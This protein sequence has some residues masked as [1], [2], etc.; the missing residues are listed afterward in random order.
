MK[1]LKETAFEY[2][3]NNYQLIL[4]ENTGRSNKGLISNSI[5]ENL[6]ERLDYFFCG[7]PEDFCKFLSK[8][9]LDLRK[10]NIHGNRIH[11]PQSLAFIK[12]HKLQ[13]VCI[14]SFNSF[15]LIDWINYINPIDIEEISLV[16]CKIY[17]N[18]PYDLEI[19]VK[20]AP[21][22]YADFINP[23]KGIDNHF[24]Q[25]INLK[26][27]NLSY[28]DTGNEFLRF[29]SDNLI[30]IEELYLSNTS[31]TDLRPIK[32]LNKLSCL[33]CSSCSNHL[34]EKSYSILNKLKEITWMDLSLNFEFLHDM[35]I[36]E[37]LLSKNNWPKLETLFLGRIESIPKDILR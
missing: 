7:I 11:N 25:F 2:L 12:S 24:K 37:D 18:Y 9:G 28:T 21:N 20:N 35:D 8:S 31:V 22:E 26:I 32:N 14:N 5:L 15:P 33:D 10:L 36:I 16:D 13:S 17:E 30:N 6:V 23:E 3:L 1:S 19:C 29:I 4:I 34:I 27:L